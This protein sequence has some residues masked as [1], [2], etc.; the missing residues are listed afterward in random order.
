MTKISL[1]MSQFLGGSKFQGLMFS[2][3]DIIYLIKKEWI[4]FMKG[5][6]IQIL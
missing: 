2:N 3:S 4:A 6:F 1:S 5:F